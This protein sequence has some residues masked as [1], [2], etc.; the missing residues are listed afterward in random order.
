MPSLCEILPAADMPR[1]VFYDRLLG[2]LRAQAGYRHAGPAELAVPAE[3][4]AQETNWPRYGHPAQAFVRGERPDLN[5]RAGPYQRYLDRLV[6]H[7]RA[8]PDQRMLVVNMHPFARM[9]R[10]FEPLANVIVADGCLSEA[11]RLANPRTV[12][13]PALP[14]VRPAE[15]DD[16]PRP[17]LA[18]FQGVD[19]HPVR[20]ALAG[21]ADG[22][23][24]VIRLVERRNHWGRIDALAGQADPAYE[25]LLDASVFG[26][27][28]RGDALFSYRLLEIIAR[29]AIPVVLS[30][31]WV[32]PFDRTL[33]WREI[34]LRIPEAEAAEAP[35]RLRA[36]P[37]ERRERLRRNGR[38]AYRTVFADLDRI[39]ATL[40][41]EAIA[42]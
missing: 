21:A 41:E 18:S 2:A 31:G 34:A 27:V 15:R 26:L 9:P 40:L 11:E 23:E 24:L 1:T 14:M 39:A 42:L 38:H 20:R 37:P 7:A 5:D 10:L 22:A 28:P 3:D 8:H 16:A 35:S 6:A 33:D 29:G 25:A 17:V 12:A 19:T 13:M 30:D 32:L 4:T 36:V